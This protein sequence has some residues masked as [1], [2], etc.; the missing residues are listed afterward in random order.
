MEEGSMTPDADIIR[1]ILKHTAC[2]IVQKRD[3]P[4]QNIVKM[5]N[6]DFGWAVWG[7][8]S[9]TRYI[10]TDELI[11][12]IV[13]DMGCRD[14]EYIINEFPIETHIDYWI[15]DHKKS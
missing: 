4:D 2:I 15:K 8:N 1:D 3:E 9:K 11:S 10:T 13:G 7:P 6:A 12:Q 14:I 5:A